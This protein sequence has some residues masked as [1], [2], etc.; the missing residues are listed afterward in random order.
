MEIIHKLIIISAV[1]FATCGIFLI[2]HPQIVQG[3]Y[4][5][6]G[7]CSPNATLKCVGN[8]VFW[9]DSCGN[10]QS[11]VK[12]CFNGCQNGQCIESQSSY[13]KHFQKSCSDNNLYWRD[14]NGIVNDLYKNCSDNNECTKDSCLDSQC[15]NEGDCNVQAIPFIRALDVSTFCGAKNES[16]NLS[17]NITVS[18]DQMIN[19]FVIV[20]NTSNDLVNDITIRVDIPSEITNTS[21]VKI[22][23]MELNGNITSGINMGNFSPIQS[24]IITF[25]GKT[26]PIINQ[27]S[28]KQITAIASFGTF[29]VADS[30]VINFQ[31]VA[32]NNVVSQA[33]PSSF[34]NF[35][36]RW[37]VWILLAIV[38]IFLFFV[39]FRRISS[40]V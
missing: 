14:S 18:A 4:Q 25:I 24:K 34:V 23:G 9:Y 33:E 31:T 17:K 26:Q 21:E 1:I 35:L 38:L 16:L 15:V 36:K 37:Y 29:S 39:I 22:D 27:I 6:P 8:S 7:L 40:N 32:T 3:Q 5:Y 2:G 19:C 13:V 12:D 10:Q 20:K 30:M 28:A 11:W